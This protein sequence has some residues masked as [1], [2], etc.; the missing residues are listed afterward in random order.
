MAIGTL[1]VFGVVVLFGWLTVREERIFMR[2]IRQQAKA[3][4]EQIVLIRHWLAD[5][6]G[7]YVPKKEGMEVNPYLKK[8]PGL[9]VE[10]T[11]SQKQTYILKNPALVT[12]EISDYAKK[13]GVIF[14]FRLTSLKPLNPDNAPTEFERRALLSF[15][16]GKRDAFAI[17][18]EAG[19]AIYRYME[20]LYI[21][22]ACL[23]CHK[24]QGYKLGDI[25]G[26]ISVKIPINSWKKELKKDKIIF[27]SLA[28]FICLTTITLIY[29]LVSRM[30]SKPLKRL[31]DT[32]RNISES[33]NYKPLLKTEDELEHLTATF[34]AMGENLKKSYQEVE[35]TSQTLEKTQ[36]QLSHRERL[37]N[38]GTLV[39]GVAHELSSPLMNIMYELENLKKSLKKDDPGGNESLKLLEGEV[40]RIHH[41]S[42]Q[43]QEIT[44][45]SIAEWGAL[46][47]NHLLK[48][49]LFHI[50]FNDLKLKGIKVDIKLA[51]T[52]PAIRASKTQIIQVLIN[53]IRNAD[54]AMAQEGRLEITTRLSIP[55]EGNVS[56][57]PYVEIEI[58]DSGS[59]IPP[60]KLPHIFEPFFTTKG[61]MGTGLGL[62]ISYN[63]IQKHRGSI[64]VQSQVGQGS[65]F[66][67]KL[68]T[69]QAD[70]D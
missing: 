52:L 54:N 34:R 57:V 37:T 55:P 63:I 69:D 8:I 32:T 7:I 42:S 50:L 43:L 44:R 53:L 20:P 60:E 27:F 30:L 47:I 33:L 22:Q 51:E 1:I 18:D 59:G 6:G 11:D 46:D 21:K 62:F 35:E 10:I 66:V 29:L 40:Q 14:Q 65:K 31:S 68:P 41:I 58:S 26:G 4:L 25:R 67:V 16:Q 12:R 9:K 17:E 19:T 70:L 38:I 45:T 36:Y 23:K 49:R 39:A 48:S 5:Q 61:A 24:F 15:R 3:Y 13:E 28:V 2:E 56:A 64:E